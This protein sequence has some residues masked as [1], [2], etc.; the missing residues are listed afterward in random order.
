MK[1]SPSQVR[2][3]YYDGTKKI[4]MPMCIFVEGFVKFAFPLFLIMLEN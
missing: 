1:T 3:G 2:I 4:L